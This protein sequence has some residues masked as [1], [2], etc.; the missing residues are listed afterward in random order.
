[1]MKKISRYGLQD[2][3]RKSLRQ[4]AEIVRTPQLYVR[5]VESTALMKLRSPEQQR[6]LRDFIYDSAAFS[7]CPSS[8]SPGSSSSS[9]SPSVEDLLTAASASSSG[10]GR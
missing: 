10:P 4:I 8:G 9:C 1:M 6:R 3:K 2:G 5:R 7:A